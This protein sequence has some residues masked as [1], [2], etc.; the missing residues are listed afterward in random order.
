LPG[1]PQQSFGGIRNLD[2]EVR[3][4]SVTVAARCGRVEA[5]ARND[6]W[7]VALQ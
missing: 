4:T 6:L 7:A 1:L 2:Q 5:Q 3:T